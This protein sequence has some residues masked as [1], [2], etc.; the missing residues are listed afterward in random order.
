MKHF[1]PAKLIGV[2][3]LLVVAT[4]AGTVVAAPPQGAPTAPKEQAPSTCEGM[5]G[6]SMSGPTT[7]VVSGDPYGP[8]ALV[9]D[10]LS[11]VCLSDDQRGAIEQLGREVKPKAEAVANARHAFVT[12]LAEQVRADNF[13][14][15]ALSPKID[16]LVKARVDA[17]PVLHKA[18]DDLH[19]ILDAG[20]RSTFVDA[21][22]SDIQ[23][24][25][26]ASK[27]L[28]ESLA[29]DLGLSDDQKAHVKDVIDRSKSDIES[30][31]D[32]TK[33]IFD[34]FKGD[35]FAI[36]K[37]APESDVGSRARERAERMVT[38]ARE[39]AGILTADQRS[40][41]AD[42]IESKAEGNA[43]G[44][45]PSGTTPPSTGT[46]GTAAP[47][48][49]APNYGAP[50]YGT[51]NTGAPSTGTPNTQAPSDENLGTTDQ[52]LF[53]GGYRA[54]GLGGWG[55]GGG[56]RAGFYRGFGGAY[57]GGYPFM[58]GF[59]PGIW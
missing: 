43:P 38:C 49:G 58:G 56:Y 17:S 8:E 30:D 21:I 7:P 20:Q 52:D 11:K 28:L 27:G 18:L 19:G 39:I 53:V 41:L 47:Q 55:W 42:K 3:G 29:K 10:A 45:N 37:L 13:D 6:K 32:R 57:V 12:T 36:D 4:A 1:T 2:V 44:Q 59:G 25:R 5:P 26:D 16:D 31:I 46:P 50:S 23:H 24:A 35:S 51:P 34:A 54:G 15:S 40:K 14:D 22:D 9:A 33:A 48:P